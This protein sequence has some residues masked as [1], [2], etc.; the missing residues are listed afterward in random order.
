[1]RATA[2]LA[3]SFALVAFA[4]GCAASSTDGP[5]TSQGPKE[6]GPETARIACGPN[7]TRVLTPRVKASPDGVHFVIDNRFGTGTGYSI[8]YPEGGGGGDVAPRGESEHVG[9]YTPG[10]V[11][12]GCEEPPVDGID[13]DYGTLEVVDP[14]GVYKSVELECKGHTAVGGGPQYSS[15]SE[16]EKGDPVELV[17]RHLSDRLR[18]DDTVESAGYPESSDHRSVRVVRDGRV[19]ATVS[20]IRDSGGWLED[21]TSNCAGFSG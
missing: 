10:K 8:E 13:L 17:R 19:V 2:A 1:M 6:K 3:C 4:G 5:G 9:G 7:G 18:K 14:G 16:G 11:R 20:F 21:S 15:G 12:I